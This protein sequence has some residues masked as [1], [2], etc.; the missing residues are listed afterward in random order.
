MPSDDFGHASILPYRV[1]VAGSTV[2]AF[3]NFADAAAFAQP[4]VRDHGAAEIVFSLTA[5]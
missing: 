5:I 2:A 1:R 4:L 3:D